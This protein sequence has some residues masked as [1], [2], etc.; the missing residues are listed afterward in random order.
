MSKAKLICPDCKSKCTLFH[1]T[2]DNVT[3]IQCTECFFDGIYCNGIDPRSRLVYKPDMINLGNDYIFCIDKLAN[4][5]TLSKEQLAE[6]N[7]KEYSKA[8]YLSHECICNYYNLDRFKVNKYRVNDTD[9]KELR[10]YDKC[11]IIGLSAIDRF[12]YFKGEV[13]EPQLRH[14]KA[15]EKF[16]RGTKK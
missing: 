8:R 1:Y 2:N 4:I 15:I 6:E 5:Y 13:F 16:L 12:G 11:G 10:K 9:R 7:K 3:W 14:V